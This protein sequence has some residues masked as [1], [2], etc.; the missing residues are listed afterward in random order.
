M[1]EADR[2]ILPLLAGWLDGELSA[3]DA[4]RVEGALERSA[5]LRA[6]VD[7]WRATDAALAGPE[8]VRSEAEWEA[9]ARRVEGAIA[10][11]AEADAER[12]TPATRVGAAP[13]WRRLAP[14]RLAFGGGG[15]LVA[16]ALVLL[17]WSRQE[18][19]VRE[20]E[21]VGARA[22][23][24]VAP[25]VIEDG[26]SRDAEPAAPAPEL[27][28]R[29]G[30][31]DEISEEVRAQEEAPDAGDLRISEEAREL[32]SPEPEAPTASSA[33]GEK[34]ATGF[35]P[36]PVG[37]ADR[38]RLSKAEDAPDLLAEAPAIE[39]AE[40]TSG[41]DL[42]AELG[43]LLDSAVAAGDVE[44]VR[45]L[46]W[47]LDR[48]R[49]ETTAGPAR[50]AAVALAARAWCELAVLE[51]EDPRS[52]ETA[53]ARVAEWEDVADASARGSDEGV[54]LRKLLHDACDR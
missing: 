40:L 53:R 49:L 3:E 25:G 14:R 15:V 4:R 36:I 20:S 45:R 10:A 43:K 46:A 26:P 52:C 32:A 6:V 42:D 7:E 2:E 9:L 50:V 35:A 1:N 24:E 39:S 16:A 12:G 29:G 34:K 13:W 21:P 30:R 48:R 5:E 33:S 27:P 54:A 19:L 17:L 23:R 37:R 28:E 18:D 41:T 11:E 31:A 47:A 8:P 51:P 22:A 38:S 44:G